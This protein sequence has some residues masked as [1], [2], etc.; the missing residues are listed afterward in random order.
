MGDEE[1]AAVGIRSGVGHRQHATPM[2][3]A[4]AGLVFEAVTRTA[5]AGAFRAA[6]LDHEIG[7]D[8]VKI[9]SVI[10]PAPG[11]VDEVGH[12]QRRLVGQQLD[13]DRATGGIEMGDQGHRRVTR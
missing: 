2:T 13:P 5:A 7:K 8:A 9:Q 12:G 11:Q 4:V 1:L 6:A 3:Y 10:E